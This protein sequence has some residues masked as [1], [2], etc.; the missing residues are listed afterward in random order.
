MGARLR[1]PFFLVRSM[2]GCNLAPCCSSRES[3]SGSLYA[4][5]VRTQSLTMNNHDLEKLNTAA[6]F[7]I[8]QRT[9]LE[10]SEQL[11]QEINHSQEPFVWSVIDLKSIER[12]LPENIRS[13]WIFV[14]KRDAPS[15]CHYHPNS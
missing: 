14:L 9:F 11:S 13:C 2:K 4:G 8:K 7:L 3:A 15:G 6:E 5:S 1:A 12:E 10:M